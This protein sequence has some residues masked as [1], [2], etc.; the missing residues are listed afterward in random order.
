MSMADLQSAESSL[1]GVGALDDP[2]AHVAAQFPSILVRGIYLS[3]KLLL[4]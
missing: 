2:T 3:W 1:R 4:L